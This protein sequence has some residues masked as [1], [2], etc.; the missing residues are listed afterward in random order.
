MKAKILFVYA[1]CVCIISSSLF[2]AIFAYMVIASSMGNWI[3][4]VNFNH[5]GEGPLELILIPV[6]AIMSIING[7][8]A[9][10]YIMKTK[11]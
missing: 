5:Y 4:I 11:L 7:F 2:T 6:V 3:V 8:W 10:K 1:T 9:S